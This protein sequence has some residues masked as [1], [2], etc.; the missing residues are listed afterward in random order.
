MHGWELLRLPGDARRSRFAGTD[1]L[2]PVSASC[3]RLRGDGRYGAS[4]RI[5]TRDGD[6]TTRPVRPT[7]GFF[8]AARRCTVS[9]VRVREEPRR[10]FRHVS[11]L[12]STENNVYTYSTCTVHVLSYESTKV[13][14]Y[15]STFE[16]TFVPS[17][18]TRYCSC[19]TVVR[20]Q[21][22]TYSTRTRTL[23]TLNVVLSYV[24]DSCTSG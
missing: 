5:Q 16:G 21:P 12:F 24:V 3:S 8:R 17:Y 19:T 15:E 4:L 22:Y 18:Y 6:T 20:V 9:S 23:Y 13:R 1:V 10:F 7:N 14:K 11:R 2:C